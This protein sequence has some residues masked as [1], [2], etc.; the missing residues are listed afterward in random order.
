[1]LVVS[2][3]LL[4]VVLGSAVFL[5]LRRELA[6][7]DR[8]SLKDAVAEVR[9]ALREGDRGADGGPV[10]RSN[11]V[12]VNDVR[13]R[14]IFFVVVRGQRMVWRSV[15]NPVP[16]R[17]L[18]KYAGQSGFSAFQY[19]GA[20]YRSY[21]LNHWGAQKERLVVYA[22]TQLDQEALRRFGAIMLEFGGSGLFLSLGF[23]LWLAR[24]A[25]RPAKDTWDAYQETITLLSHELQTPLATM[26]AILASPPVDE[27]A[28]LRL[29]SELKRASDLV[30]D[31]LYLSLLRTK[32]RATSPYPVA[33][34]DI[35]EDC[36]L[37]FQELAS[38]RAIRF[39]GTAE[40][41]LYVQTTDE[42]WERLVSTVFKNV[43]DHATHETDAVWKLFARSHQV[44]LT[45]SNQAHVS[46]EKSNHPI[47]RGVG[48]QIV[49]RLVADMGG[50]WEF[51]LMDGQVHVVVRI[52]RLNR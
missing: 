30:S 26:Q 4:L 15:A 35:T 23:N 36:A 32:I 17:I 49:D 52:P 24:R 33:V 2:T 51:T 1:M 34:S 7:S 12:A 13:G 40:P 16:L 25:I 6:D 44:V 50:Q 8:S 18:L 37:R 21:T 20:P 38:R 28:R 27:G 14:N 42:K 29:G 39:Y 11:A 45:T 43:V 5:E 48:L 19:G 31:M 22:K 47:S 46:L 10:T 9:E 3:S 41:G